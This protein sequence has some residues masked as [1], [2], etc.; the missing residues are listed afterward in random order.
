MNAEIT[1]KILLILDLDETLIHSSNKALNRPADFQVFHYHVYK[2]PFIKEFLLGCNEHFKLVIWSSASDDYVEE[3]VKKIIPKNIPLQFIWGRS[4]CTY[5]LNIFSFESSPDDY[6]NHYHYTKVL[7]KVKNR[8]YSLD[9]VL[10]IDD[11]PTKSRRN[12]GN[13][14]YPAVYTGDSADNEL[15]RLLTYLIELKD[16]ENVRAIEKRNWKNRIGEKDE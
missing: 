1:D 2:R 16:A 11:T 12:Y 7:K 8:S 9:R 10:I 13:A 4:R 6:F 5:C 14:I 3:I 15:P